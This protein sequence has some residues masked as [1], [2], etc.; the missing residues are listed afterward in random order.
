[1]TGRRASWP[2]E[3]AVGEED[4][5]NFLVVRGAWHGAVDWNKVSERL[6]AIGHRVYAINLPGSG[7]NAAYPS[8]YL[9]NDFTAFATE[10]SPIGGIH[11]AD[12]AR[13]I[14]AQAA[15]GGRRAE[16][17]GRRTA[18]GWAGMMPSLRSAER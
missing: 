12:Y 8:S 7:L 11:L 13:A 17:P 6:A 3:A 4:R 16:Q 15:G 9:R 2:E 14:T 10:P 18:C 5:Q 1:M